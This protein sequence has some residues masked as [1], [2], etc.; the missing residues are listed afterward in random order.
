MV[1]GRDRKPKAEPRPAPKGAVEIETV[2]GTNTSIKGD[3]RSSGGVRIEGDF[4][5]TIDIAGNLVVG[6]AAQVVADIS[7]HNIQIQGTAQGD[8]TA[9]RLEILD[10]GKLWGNIDVDSFVLDDGGL[11]QGQSKMQGDAR[12]PLLE[13]PG[14]GSGEV[15][16]GQVTVSEKPKARQP[17]G[18][19]PD[20]KD[21]A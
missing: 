9:R 10:T 3:L 13:A 1:F 7:A 8:V 21:G 15:L 6:E 2:I 20:G 12:P 18:D 16:D 19:R 4:E 11:F 14:H 17:V 5:G